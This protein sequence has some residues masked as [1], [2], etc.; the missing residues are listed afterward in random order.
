VEQD[1]DVDASTDIVEEVENEHGRFRAFR[2]GRVRVVFADRTILQVQ[3]SGD[4]CKF[5]FP[6]G[7]SG[8]STL[9]SA[10]LQQRMYIHRALEFADWAFASLEERMERFRRRQHVQEVSQQELKRINVRFG[11]N[12]EDDCIASSASQEQRAVAPETAVAG[13]SLEMLRQVQSETLRHMAAVD[14]ALQSARAVAD[15]AH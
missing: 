3:H 15:A 11:L 1:S 4:T 10:P 8:T 6:D 9:A 12:S 14:Q 5:F 2:D 7:S 13:L